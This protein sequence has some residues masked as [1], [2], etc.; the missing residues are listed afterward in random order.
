MNVRIWTILGGIAILG[1]V[2]VVLLVVIRLAKRARR[3]QRGFP[4]STDKQ[5]AEE[6]ARSL[7]RD[8]RD[9]LPPAPRR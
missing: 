9:K 8:A 1:V 2:A 4:V 6:N 5:A 7:E 3:E